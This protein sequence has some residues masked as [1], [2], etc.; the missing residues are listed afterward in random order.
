MDPKRVL[1]WVVKQDVPTGKAHALRLP[2]P[3]ADRSCEGVVHVA[4]LVD[5]RYCIFLKT[6][7]GWK[8]NFEGVFSCTG[9]LASEEIIRRDVNAPPFISLRGYGIFQELY[10]RRSHRSG[11]VDVY[12]DL[13]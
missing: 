3:L 2:P 1:E 6:S 8:D 12:F 4:H 9:L 5:G 7:I 13:N 10:V 11:W